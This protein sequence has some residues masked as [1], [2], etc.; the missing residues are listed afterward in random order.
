MTDS[1]ATT[2]APTYT[3]LHFSG[4]P[5][6]TTYITCSPEAAKYAYLHFPTPYS[7]EWRAASAGFDAGREFSA[8]IIAEEI[9]QEVAKFETEGYKTGYNEAVIDSVAQTQAQLAGSEEERRATFTRVKR[10][11]KDDMGQPY[12]PTDPYVAPLRTK[13]AIQMVQNSPTLAA[14]P[15]DISEWG[16][17]ATGDLEPDSPAPR[18]PTKA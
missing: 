12:N 14:T 17:M 5:M 9:A 3:K 13:Q 8:G 10:A 15:A 18:R 2:Q 6:T 7:N 16:T 11:L 4:D 1:P